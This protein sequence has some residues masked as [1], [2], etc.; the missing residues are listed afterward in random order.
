MPVNVIFHI[1][2]FCGCN[3]NFLEFWWWATGRKRPLC[4][5]AVQVHGW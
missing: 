5:S 2:M 1:E 4:S 3:I